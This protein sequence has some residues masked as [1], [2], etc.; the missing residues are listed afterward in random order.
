MSV[1][2][3]DDEE[4]EEENDDE[5]DDEDLADYNDDSQVY[6]LRD[7][8]SPLLSCLNHTDWGCD[9]TLHL[10]VCTIL[11]LPLSLTAYPE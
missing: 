3:E 5:E 6:N 2:N 7:S 11:M 8:L 10:S 9:C 4:E 1:E